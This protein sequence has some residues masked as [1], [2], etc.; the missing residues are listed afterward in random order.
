MGLKHRTVT[1]ETACLKYIGNETAHSTK[2]QYS[3][4]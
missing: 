3:G 4:L 2:K 1:S